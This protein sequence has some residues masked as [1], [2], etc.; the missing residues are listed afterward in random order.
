MNGRTNVRRSL[1]KLQHKF[2]KWFSGLVLR[3]LTSTSEESKSQSIAYIK[4]MS[5]V[6]DQRYWTKPYG[7]PEW[8]KIPAGE[9]WMGTDEFLDEQPKHRVH[10]PTF[11]M[12]RVPITNEQFAL[13]IKDSGYRGLHWERRHWSSDGCVL[14]GFENHPVASAD[15]HDAWAY[16]EWLSRVTGKTIRLPSEAEW[17]KA[18]R[19]SDDARTYPWGD[20][21]GSFRCNS[22]EFGLRNTTPVGIFPTG[23][24]PYGLL[25][26]SGNV[27]EWTCSLYRPYPYVPESDSELVRWS[28][29]RWSRD[30]SELVVCR[31]GNYYNDIHWGR[32]AARDHYP[33]DIDEPI[34]LGFRVVL[35]SPFDIEF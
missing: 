8:V 4:S 35:S 11:W 27:C 5:H 28:L 31:G 13:F 25:D 19:G 6:S 20:A 14:S 15:L 12:A 9:F 10:L 7:E 22:S 2:W 3:L 32:C 21:P 1:R 30:N 34:G 29:T 26:M 23:A 33:G 17:E 18:V 24:S 16:C